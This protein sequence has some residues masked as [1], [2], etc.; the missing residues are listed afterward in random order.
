M[1]FKFCFDC[2]CR[3]FS[4]GCGIIVVINILYEGNTLYISTVSISTVHVVMTQTSCWCDCRCRWFSYGCGLTLQYTNIRECQVIVSRHH[5]ALLSALLLFLALMPTLYYSL[6]LSSIG[7]FYL[8]S[9]P[10]SSPRTAYFILLLYTHGNT[11]G[12]HAS[13]VYSI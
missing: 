7:L 12:M 13:S 8:L 2:R 10:K 4:C 3:W 1:T 5:A 9:L 11:V 6:T